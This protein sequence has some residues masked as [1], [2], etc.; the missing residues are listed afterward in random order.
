MNTPS[1]VGGVLARIATG[2]THDTDFPPRARFLSR[3]RVGHPGRRP[4]IHAQDLPATVARSHSARI[5]LF[6]RR[7]NRTSLVMVQSAGSIGVI[8]KPTSGGHKKGGAGSLPPHFLRQHANNLN[9]TDFHHRRKNRENR[10]LPQS[11][12][13]LNAVGTLACDHD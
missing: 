5:L 1:E 2:G 6:L 3:W 10:D 11:F 13:R 7:T 4:W 9:R 8:R 12:S